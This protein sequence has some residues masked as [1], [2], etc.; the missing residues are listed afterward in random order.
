MTNSSNSR[1]YQ[2]LLNRL[3]FLKSAYTRNRIFY[4]ILLF[5]C[6]ALVIA[7]LGLWANSIF[8]F[9]VVARVAYLGSAALL[10]V[11]LF[12]YF[13]IRP[14]VYK[15][16]LEE[17]ALKVEDRFPELQ[18]RLIAALQLSRHLKE[19]PEGYS[20][21]LIEEVIHQADSVSSRLDLKQIM[22]K[23]PIRRMGRMA[24]T[25]ATLWLIFGLLF[26]LGF[27][28]SLYVFSHPLTEFSPPPEFSFIISPGN[29]QAVKFSDVRIK[30]DVEGEKPSSVDL[31]WR[32]EGADWN[33]EKL[34]LSTTAENQR[35][36]ETLKL[37]PDFVWQFKEVKR[38]FEYYAQA[39]GI[40]SE[41]YKITVVD[42]PRIVGLKLTFN[43]PR[44]TRL[45][46]QVTDQN[47][48]NITAIAGT[49]VMIE[50]T[51]NKE[52][53]KGEIVFSDST[54][55]QTK[56]EGNLVSSEILIR[57]DGAYYIDLWDQSGNQSQDPIEY[58]ITSIADRFPTVDILE[59]GHDQ[60]LT[61][62]MRVG[63]LFRISDDYGFS[64]LRLRYRII[65]GGEES[66]E[67]TRDID[68]PAKG[69]SETNVEYLWSLA[70]FPL[71]PGD[72]VSYRAVVYDNDTFSGPKKGESQIYYLRL[73][74]LDEI[75]AEVEQEQ[76]GQ[77]ADLE[78]V[79]RG[80]KD[81]KKKIEDLSQEMNRWTGLDMDWQ[82]KQEMEDALNRQMKLT[83]DLKD[84]SKKMDQSIKKVEEN[85]LA[86]A[87]MVEKMMEI[88][89]LMEEVATPEMK[90]ALRQLAEAMKNMDP[91][92]LKQAVKNMQLSAE[93]ML[94]RLERTLSLLKRMQAEQKLSNLIK[95]SEQMVEEQ[96]KIN[97]STDSSAK[98]DLPKL[99]S[100]EKKLKDQLEQFEEELK[101]FAD[102]ASQLSML[103]PK[104]LDKLAN[105]AEQSGI[106]GDMDQM[107]SQ[108]SSSNQSGASKSGK[109]CS[110]KLQ[111]MQ[112][113][114]T[115]AQQ[116][117][118]EEQKE[119]IVKA[120]KKSLF[121]VFS[122]SDNQEQLYDKISAF[123]N[124]D[125]VLRDQAG[126][127]QNLK[128]AGF[129]ISED[130]EALSHITLFVSADILRYVALS[131]AGMEE[132]TKQLN[133]LRGD[134]A[135]DEQREAI[136]DLNVTARKLMQAMASANK[137][138]SGSGMQE[139][140]KKMSGMCDKQGGINQQTMQLGQ[141]G[142]DGNQPSLAQQ[143]AMQRLAAEQEAVRKAL[144]ELE[145]EF[146]NSSEIA[147]RLDKIG[148]EMKKVVEDFERMRVD[149]TTIDR[150]KQIL[151]RLL[152]TEKSMR[153]RDYSKQRRAEVGE[154]V[155]RTSPGE[156]SSETL[157]SEE[158]GAEDLTRF[159]QEAYPKEYEQLIKEYFKALSE[160]KSKR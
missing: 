115:S 88:K 51:A 87:E 112:E 80:Q 3:G 116:D 144:S 100:D 148:Q 44:Y 33:K 132:A 150:Q 109:S 145:R 140:F 58:K 157:Q 79:L 71:I 64:S 92:Q 49:R 35:T 37:E 125:L 27:K 4:G 63:L 62:S 123:G 98:E 24:V 6:F 160:E 36:N 78:T 151:S 96:N 76:E 22:D 154:D 59:P 102:L 118:Q 130:L 114:L 126:K 10:L 86:A 75:I 136:Y 57:K 68:I 73:P 47:D 106:K 72:L 119:E 8:L 147:G 56:V 111:Q 149:Q 84:I 38:S 104:R 20:T 67:R 45:K 146:G 139:M 70:D 54:R 69:Q 77:I 65:S 141:C 29:G 32:N 2:T 99:A 110:Q 159:M 158:R 95:K 42:K 103:P 18:N 128:S 34:P 25:L 7:F 74:S 97:Q 41:L 5:L 66:E 142:G 81:L 82:K 31:F 134:I 21:D 16:S 1:S 23:T 13:C 90:E 11:V 94:K 105:M 138:C 19:N 53:D 91:E 135:A 26:P 121:D 39:Q 120:I 28:T 124:R 30:I 133:E 107:I 127:Q 60:D 113:Q 43:Y 93:E 131:V 55:K 14:M 12:S 137:S 83:Q 89:K 143:A 50:A 152:D 61:E 129:R 40:K 153:E 52:L 48:G 117:M 108:L 122:L 156:L 9:P 15:S 85:K 101:E 155:S 46:T 17:L